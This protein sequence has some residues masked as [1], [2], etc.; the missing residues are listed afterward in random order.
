MSNADPKRTYLK[1]LAPGVLDP[2]FVERVEG[3]S[4]K[5]ACLKFHAILS[6]PLD[7]SG[8]LGG[9]YDPR[10]STYVTL[11]PDGFDTYRTA[12]QA[13]QR[14][15]IPEAPVCHIRVPTAYDATLTEQDS[16][17]LS[18]WTL[19]APNAP[20]AGT[21]EQLREEAAQRLID[22]V[23]SFIPNFRSAI[24]EYELFTPADIEARVGIT[25]GCIRHIDMIPG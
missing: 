16:E 15:E 6:E 8:Y 2:E 20:A 22:H 24:R 11:A 1:L 25:D 23:T 4:T 7:L 19:Y 14:G 18:I 12:W 3:L 13:A 17:I 9:D 21:W 10:Y 5:A